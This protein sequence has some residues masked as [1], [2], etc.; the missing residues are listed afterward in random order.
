MLIKLIEIQNQTN[1]V[2]INQL[3]IS[4]F[5]GVLFSYVSNVVYFKIISKNITLN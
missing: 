1:M 5:Y 4:I 2:I 3:G